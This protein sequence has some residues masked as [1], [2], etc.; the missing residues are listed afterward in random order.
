MRD[1]IFIS[2]SHKDNI[3]LERLQTMLKPLVRDGK[4]SVWDDTKIRA[5]E[6]WENEIKNA[7][8]AAKVAILLV[9]PAFLASDFIAQHELPPIL[10]AAKRE[11][12][13]ILWIALH[14]SLY[15]KTAIRGYQ[16][17]NEP[18]KPLAT[19][20]VKDR[21][22]ELVKICEQIIQAANHSNE[23]NGSKPGSLTDHEQL[24]QFITGNGYALD[25]GEI[26]KIIEAQVNPDLCFVRQRELDDLLHAVRTGNPVVLSGPQGAGK[27]TL[28]KQLQLKCQDENIPVSYIDLSAE[29]THFE[30]IFWRTIVFSLTNSD[31]GIIS[32]FEAEEHLKDVIDRS[33]TCLDNIDVFARSL[34]TSFVQ[35][36]N[37]LRH[38]IQHRIW[39]LAGSRHLS[40]SIV[41]TTRDFHTLINTFKPLGPESPWFNLYHVIH[42]TVLSEQRALELLRSTGIHESS[43]LACLGMAKERLPFDLLLLAYLVKI[44]ATSGVVE[45]ERIKAIYLDIRRLLY[46][47]HQ[48]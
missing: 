45:Y 12:L 1:Q 2:Y 38:L 14:A 31:P 33:V 42:L 44:H 23:E 32:R 43:Q 7:L 47:D 6:E 17:A 25:R 26:Q 16:A 9:S 37:Y 39:G 35:E 21:E 22:S 46:S 48:V 4:L 10:D 18:S 29:D 34:D 41:L 28:L 19:L 11:G 8:A 13:I 20:S 15:Q 3:W 27:T 40:N 5:G 30:S 36:M 24:L